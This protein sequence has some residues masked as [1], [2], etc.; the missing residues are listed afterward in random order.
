M[1]N[2]KKYELQPVKNRN[3]YK[4]KP[5][6]T[7]KTKYFPKTPFSQNVMSNTRIDTGSKKDVSGYVKR[8]VYM[9]DSHGN[10]QVAREVQVINSWKKIG[11]FS[12]DE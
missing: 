12:T 3:I 4:Q 6:Y 11:Y 9:R 2:H 7:N 5:K 8:E 1:S 10:V